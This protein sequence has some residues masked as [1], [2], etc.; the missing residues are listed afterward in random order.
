[1]DNKL[2]KRKFLKGKNRI[3]ILEIDFYMNK[4]LLGSYHI[5]IRKNFDPLWS[6]LS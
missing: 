4:T 2:W 5:L 6:K 1:M 3:F